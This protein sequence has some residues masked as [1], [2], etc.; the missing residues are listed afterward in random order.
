MPITNMGGIIINLHWTNEPYHWHVKDEEEVFVV[1]AG[2]VEMNYKDKN[3]IKKILLHPG[4]IF[5]ATVGCE[6]VA[7]PQ[8]EVRILVIEK[9]GSI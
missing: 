4:D 1:L 7:H 6:H 3:Q 8:G 9:E 2:V 5:H